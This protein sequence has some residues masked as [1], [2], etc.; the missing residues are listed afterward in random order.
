MLEIELAK[1]LRLPPL[2]R[3]EPKLTEK[4]QQIV[5]A[6]GYETMPYRQLAARAELKP[7]S[8]LRKKLAGMVRRGLLDNDEGGYSLG[9]L[10]S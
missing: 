7:N 6:L 8:E 9:P 1:A 10:L 4:E 3:A 5:T 2:K